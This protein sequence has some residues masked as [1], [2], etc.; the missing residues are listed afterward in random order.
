M[1]QSGQYRIAAPADAV[2]LALNDPEVLLYCIDGCQSMIRTGDTTFTATV[3]ATMG[4]LSGTFTADIKL[5]EVDPPNAY[6][7]EASVKG[8]AAGFAK[9]VAH[10][11]LTEETRETLLRYDV[12]G[13]VG[14][15]L[16]EA[17]E[18][19]VDAAARKAAA[20]F[21]TRFGEVLAPVGAATR[22]PAP[23]ARPS[24]LKPT[25]IA[26]A[27][28]AALLALL[29]WFR[30]PGGFRK[31]ACGRTS[32]RL[33]RRPRRRRRRRG[34]P[35][36]PPRRRWWPRLSTPTALDEPMARPGGIFRKP[37]STT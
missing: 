13:N 19:L 3:K 10:V 28:I 25:L 17:G 32:Q 34:G 18:R 37:G 7:L 2:W 21:F 16:A 30:G 5:A 26:V 8:G 1:R 20:D 31:R 35:P 11:A 12:E 22:K 15:K 33:S 29:R 24:R 4:S 6:T 36:T 9:G 14:G 27:A 23:A